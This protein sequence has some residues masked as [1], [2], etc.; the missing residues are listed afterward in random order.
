M[1]NEEEA[2]KLYSDG[3][4]RNIVNQIKEDDLDAKLVEDAKLMDIL[5]WAQHQLGEY[6]LAYQIFLGLTFLYSSD[7]EVG[8]SSRRGAAHA[9]LQELGDV[10]RAD[11][12]LQEIPDSMS[13]QN[14][15][16]NIFLIAARKG[17]RIPFKKIISMVLMAVNS[18][19]GDVVNAHIVNNGG[20][21]LYEARRH[22][23]SKKLLLEITEL[24]EV[25]FIMYNI[26]GAA[27]N[28][29]A[30]LLYR[31]SLVFETFGD[32]K[33]ALQSLRKSVKIWRKLV[34]SQGGERYQNNLKNTISKME[35]LSK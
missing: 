7:T 19:S 29:L 14:V 4:Y 26:A 25:A 34:S 30:G 27:D 20:L 16:M 22:F 28:H 32:S 31:I 5:A 10:E 18:F 35:L 13:K 1:L 15:R 6:E 3:K 24:L 9:V 2:R 33:R 12:F 23:K 11:A 21:A 8:E 17:I